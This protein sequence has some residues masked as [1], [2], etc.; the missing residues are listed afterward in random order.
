MFI[1]ILNVF[2]VSLFLTSCS[3]NEKPSVEILGTV[4][5]IAV[6]GEDGKLKVKGH[7]EK[8]LRSGDGVV[9]YVYLRTNMKSV[10]YTEEV[11][12]NG[13]SV[14]GMGDKNKK[15]DKTKDED[16]KTIDYK[17][18]DDG[19]KVVVLKEA[20]NLKGFIFGTWKMTDKDPVGPVKIRVT[21][22]NQ[23]NADFSWDLVKDS[24]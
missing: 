11:I 1:R 22:E 21:V 12:L 20:K 4:Q 5:G 19:S 2:L 13:S 7:E 3:N 14:W 16:V 18:S 24:K 8:V 10:R 9:W 17:I 6:L 15:S 23:V